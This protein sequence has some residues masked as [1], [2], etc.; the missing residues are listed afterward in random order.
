MHLQNNRHFYLCKKKE[1]IRKRT[2]HGYMKKKTGKATVNNTLLLLKKTESINQCRVRLSPNTRQNS[3]DSYNNQITGSGKRIWF[4]WVKRVS[5]RISP[6]NINLSNQLGLLVILHV[7]SS[8]YKWAFFC[9][10][11]IFGF[12][13]CGDFPS[14]FASLDTYIEC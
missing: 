4:Y 14:H 1:L 2:L 10:S 3:E 5:E 8:W 6:V 13:G 7:H 11:D 9:R 12:G